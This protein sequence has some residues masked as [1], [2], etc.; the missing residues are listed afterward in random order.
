MGKI[1]VACSSGGHFQEMELIKKHFINPKDT[2]FYYSFKSPMYD[3]IKDKFYFVRDPK[4]NPIL[5]FWNMFYSLYI[6]LKESP[7]KVLTNGASVVFGMVFWAWIFRKKI[8]YIESFCRTNKKSLTGILLYPISNKFYVFWTQMLEKYGK[9]VKLLKNIFK[10]FKVKKE[11]WDKAKHVFVSVGSSPY[12]F[13]RLIEFVDKLAI[14]HKEKQFFCQVGT[15][16]YIPKSK[17]IKYV[18]YLSYE[19]YNR[20]LKNSDFFISHAGAGSIIS[21]I[22]Y[23]KPIYVMARLKKYNEI[24]NDHQLEL[25]AFVRKKTEKGLIL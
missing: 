14:K 10:D 8:I 4:R 21:A 11:D 23:K 18:D 6:L 5:H 25:E 15:S 7:D 17:N 16:N 2:L 22:T 19:E 24:I 9:K 1:C 12:Q 20:Y 3:G 13:N